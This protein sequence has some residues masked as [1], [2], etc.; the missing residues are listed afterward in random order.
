MQPGEQWKS[1]SFLASNFQ[2]VQRGALDP[3]R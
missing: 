3:E 2:D 1:K